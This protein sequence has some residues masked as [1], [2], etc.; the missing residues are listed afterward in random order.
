MEAGIGEMLPN[1]LCVVKRS[2][3]IVCKT[4]FYRT[5]LIQ[6]GKLMK[7]NELTRTDVQSSVKASCLNPSDLYLC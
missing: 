4:Y 5:R 3:D 2:D 7:N 6:K 1:G